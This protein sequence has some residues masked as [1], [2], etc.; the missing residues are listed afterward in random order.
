VSAAADGSGKADNQASSA[1][2]ILP[3]DEFNR[4]LVSCAHPLNWNNPIPRGKYN[5]VVIGAGTAGLVAAAGG[6][7]LG[8]KVALIE[9]HLLGGDCLNV[10]CVPSKALISAARMAQDARAGDHYGVRVPSVTVDFPAVMQRMRRL[11]ARLAIVDS[12]ERFKGLGVDVY[13]G[14]GHFVDRNTVEVDGKRIEF[15]RAVVATGARAAAP[16]IEGLEAAG[17]LTNETVFWLTELPKQLVVIG[18]GPIGCEMAQT[19]SRFGSEVTLIEEATHILV[20]EDADAARIV[21]NRIEAEGVQLICGAKITRVEKRDSVKVVHLRSGAIE[22]AVSCDQI[23][24]GVGR[25]PNLE[26]LGLEAAGIDY[27]RSGVKVD[28]GLRTTNAQVYAAGDICTRFKF[29]HT[30]DALARV[31]LTNALFLGRRKAS[32]LNVPWCT[33]TSPEIAHVGMYEKDAVERA[34]EPRTITVKMDGIDRAV[35]DG[36]DEGFVRIHLKKGTD[37]ILGATIVAEHAGEMIS[38]ISL[39]MSAGVGLG[40]I[41]NVIHPYPTQAEAIRKAADAYNRTRLTPTVKKLF[42]LWLALRRR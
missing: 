2:L 8:A 32:A 4:V 25:A 23:L 14:D 31:V 11:R 28:D 3:D 10:G 29:T 6:A 18:A 15:A 26:G 22:K 39:A 42:K 5:L 9:R 37:K 33:Y 41:A 27:D 35:L 24:V 20:R 7:G 1:P 40:A 16:P 30:A 19:F 36:R 34:I 17:Y 38:E 12:A 13:I 21:E